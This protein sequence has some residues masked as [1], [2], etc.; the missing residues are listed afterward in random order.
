MREW[1]IS[2]RLMA[3]RLE[4]K[5]SRRTSL[6][7]Q[8]TAAAARR[9][10]ALLGRYTGFFMWRE[11]TEMMEAQQQAQSRIAQ[12]MAAFGHGQ[13]PLTDERFGRPGAIGYADGFSGGI[14]PDLA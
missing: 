2:L 13:S 7:A 9:A 6:T 10:A 5:R 8:A 1:K 14:S 3:S 12:Q 4:A 11:A